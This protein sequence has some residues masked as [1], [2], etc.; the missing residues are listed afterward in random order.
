MNSKNNET[1]KNAVETALSKVGVVFDYNE[2]KRETCRILFGEPKTINY[3]HGSGGLKSQQYSTVMSF[4]DWWS[5]I[6]IGNG[7]YSSIDYPID[8]AEVIKQIS[9]C[10]ISLEN[11]ECIRKDTPR[12]VWPRG[13]RLFDAYHG[14]YRDIVFIDDGK[15]MACRVVTHQDYVIEDWH[16]LSASEVRD[17]FRYGKILAGYNYRGSSQNPL[18]KVFAVVASAFSS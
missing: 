7:Y 6:S 2:L 4:D 5:A 16:E 1:V 15:F 14:K 12:I 13:N 18:E 10:C 3:K 17:L 8:T 9:D 11:N